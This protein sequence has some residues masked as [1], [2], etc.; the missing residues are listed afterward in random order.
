MFSKFSRTRVLASGLFLF[1]SASA[2]AQTSAPAPF[3]LQALRAEAGQPSVYEITLTF[4]QALAADAE[5][6]LEFPP[7]FDLSMLLV[8]GSPDI[9]GGFT[10]AREG[11]RVRVKR[12][13][14]G[15]RVEA[16][17]PVRLRLGAVMNPDKLEADYQISV[18]VQASVSAALSEAQ[19]TKVEF[20]RELAKE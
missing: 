11:Q 6:V 19:K 2:F 15:E 7:A 16:N 10:L 3:R 1:L 14:A 5:F 17:K 8:A 4:P 20:Q 18:Q 9:T 12:S 13:G